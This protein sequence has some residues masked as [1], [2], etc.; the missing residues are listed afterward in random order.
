V[1]RARQEA[2]QLQLFV[3]AMAQE[4]EGNRSTKGSWVDPPATRTHEQQLDYLLVDVGYHVLKLVGA[5]RRLAAQD[6]ATAR[7]LL[8][9]ACADIGNMA[10][11]FAT[12]AGVLTTATLEER[13]AQLRSGKGG[14]LGDGQYTLGGGDY[15]L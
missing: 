3:E 13:H 14:Y 1:N 11:V 4:L 15:D 2:K 6:D 5:R 12:H 8:L 7:A 9:E 10:L